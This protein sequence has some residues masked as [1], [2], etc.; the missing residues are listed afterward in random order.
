MSNDNNNREDWEQDPPEYPDQNDDED[1]DA[2]WH[3]RRERDQSWQQSMSTEQWLSLDVGE[4]DVVTPQDE[5]HRES[6]F[7]PSDNQEEDQ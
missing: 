6:Y 3:P 4:P 2:N 5:Y 1:E 7:D